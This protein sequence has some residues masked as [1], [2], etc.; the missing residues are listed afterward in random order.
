MP[1]LA[2]AGAGTA[3]AG[4]DLPGADAWQVYTNDVDGVANRRYFGLGVRLAE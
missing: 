3:L 4:A 2:R 1:V